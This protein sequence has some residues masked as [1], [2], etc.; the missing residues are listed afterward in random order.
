MKRSKLTTTIAKNKQPEPCTSTIIYPNKT[1]EYLQ[2]KGIKLNSTE[3]SPNQPILLR[4]LQQN[5]LLSKGSSSSVSI[6]SFEDHS[7]QHNLDCN[8]WKKSKEKVNRKDMF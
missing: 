3:S 8:D 2:L 5:S 7:F 4:P 1:N 6:L